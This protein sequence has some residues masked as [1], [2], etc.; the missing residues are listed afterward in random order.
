MLSLAL[1][2]NRDRREIEF[3]VYTLFPTKFPEYLTQTIDE[4]TV[5][6]DKEMVDSIFE[7]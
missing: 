2:V 3:L 6:N 1:C 5:S 4:E 7:K